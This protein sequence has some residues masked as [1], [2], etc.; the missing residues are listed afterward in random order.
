MDLLQASQTNNL[1]LI[2]KIIATNIFDIEQVDNNLFTPLMYA[3]INANYE[4]V[5]LLLL[6]NANPNIKDI[7]DNTP[8]IRAIS[9]C[10]GDDEYFKIIQILLTYGADVKV[11]L[12]ALCNNEFHNKFIDI[13]VQLLNHNIDVNTRDSQK[14]SPLMLICRY[15]QN[16]DVIKLLLNSGADV[17]FTDH[18]NWSAL[19]ITCRFNNNLEIAKLLLAYGAKVNIR[20]NDGDTPLNLACMYTN[21]YDFIKLLIKYGAK[22]NIMNDELSTPLINACRYARRVGIIDNNLK[23]INLLLD[24]DAD[25]NAVD[26]KG[27]TPLLHSRHLQILETL[28]NHGADINHQNNLGF[29]L[30]M[31]IIKDKHETVLFLLKHGADINVRNK[32]NQSPLSIALIAM[33][34][35]KNVKLLIRLGANINIIDSFTSTPVLSLACMYYTNINIIRMLI[36][37][38]LDINQI[39]PSNNTPLLHACKTQMNSKIIKLLLKSGADI[40]ILNKKNQSALIIACQHNSNINNIKVLLKSNADVNIIDNQGMTALLHLLTKE[41]IKDNDLLMWETPYQNDTMENQFSPSFNKI[42]LLIIYNANINHFNYKGENALMLSINHSRVFNYLINHPKIELNQ[43]NQYNESILHT[44]VEF[45][46]FEQVKVLL[47]KGCNPN[48]YSTRKSTPYNLSVTNNNSDVT[49]LLLKYNADI[50]LTM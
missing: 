32:L 2:K 5:E 16:I 42:K 23:I 24:N 12:L 36:K 11:G 50:N 33:H 8:L 27:N 21:N 19:I 10:S 9:R 20:T 43:V 1:E 40:N 49:E 30:L 46:T 26:N 31:R 29:S 47:Q 14:W 22:I 25:V 37:C 15:S 39:D 34:H 13:I 38:K 45:G 4:L 28:L 35:D 6:N 41:E 17:N 18:D 7:N 48:I 44:A 3:V